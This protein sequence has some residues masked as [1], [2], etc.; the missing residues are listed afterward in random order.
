MRISGVVSLFLSLLI[1]VAHAA[2]A[3]NVIE[4]A[5]REG[6]LIWWTSG[7]VND[8]RAWVKKF[9]QR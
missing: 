4:A 3:P 2:P 7:S 9:N 1:G 8:S 6:K 5:K